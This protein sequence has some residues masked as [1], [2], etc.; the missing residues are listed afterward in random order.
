MIHNDL[1]NYYKSNYSLHAYHKFTLSEIDNLIPFEKRLY[2]QM[3]I[4]TIKE[5]ESK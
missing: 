4:N 2:T 5:I 1:T 3:I